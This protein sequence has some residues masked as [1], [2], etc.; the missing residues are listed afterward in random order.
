[1]QS[2]LFK[3]GIYL[4]FPLI[5]F[6]NFLFADPENGCELS[7]NTLFLTTSAEV[8]YNSNT[9][10]GGFQFNV[11]GAT[12]NGASGGD[13]ANAGF[14]VS[15]GGMTVLGFSFTGG[16]VPAGCGTLTNLDLNGF[17]TSLSGIVVSDNL[18]NSID[19]LYYDEG[20]GDDGDCDDVDNDGICDD[21][22]DC[23]GS[24]DDC[25]VCNGNNADMD[26]AGECG[27]SAM[28]DECGICDGD[29][30]S[31]EGDLFPNVQK[32]FCDLTN[33]LILNL[34]MPL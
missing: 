12:V 15:A 18:G 29:G 19:F 2:K 9:D 17:G 14:T 33:F 16:V 5:T 31:C 11:D 24:Y 4:L 26:C 13:A 7:E 1:M 21:I 27:G 20:G 3:S 22:D 10:I 28:F 30:S 25:G 23:I 32:E 6:F 8:F 34:K